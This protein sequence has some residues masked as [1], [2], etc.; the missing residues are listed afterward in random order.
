MRALIHHLAVLAANGPWYCT[1]CGHQYS[2]DAEGAA[3]MASAH[4]NYR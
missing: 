3:H 4:P 1:Y 2:T